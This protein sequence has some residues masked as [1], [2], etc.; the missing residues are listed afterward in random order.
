MEVLIIGGGKV[1][2]HL[3]G[4]LLEGG[5]QVTLIE[6]RREK[7]ERLQRDLPASR[8]QCGSGSD[9][10]MLESAGVRR[11]G[12]VAAVT[13]DDETNL[14]IACLA[15]LAFH[16][17]RILARVNNPKNAWMFTNDMGV[18]VALNQADLMARLIAEEMSLGDMMTL[19]KLRRGQFAVVEEKIHPT[20]IAAGKRISDL[21]LPAECSLV[22]ILRK[23]RVLMPDPGTI[24][25]PADEV[26][27]V[28]HSDRMQ[29][30]AM[31]LGRTTAPTVD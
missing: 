13:G 16:A 22:A 3:A 17:P 23:G 6:E 29:E 31:L 26:L 11:A 1:G 21:Q 18:D 19:M 14:T 27:A 4:L 7:V 10:L 12:V 15:R 30:M 8:V 5:H 25:Q 24:L 20:A 9:P 28:V 2:A